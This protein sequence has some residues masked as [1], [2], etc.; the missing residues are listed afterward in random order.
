MIKVLQKKK[1][2][3]ATDNVMKKAQT[4]KQKREKVVNNKKKGISLFGFV[5]IIGLIPLLISLLI[6]SIVAITVI[7]NNLESSEENTLRVAAQNLRSYCEDNGVTAMNASDYYN[8]IDG[9]KD[10]GIELAIIAPGIP[11]TTSIKNENDFRIREI[12]LGIDLTADHALYANGYYDKHVEANEQSY[13]AYYMPVVQNGEE[14][15]VA[16]AGQLKSSVVGTMNQLV[17]LFVCITIVLFA[18][19]V[20]LV[21]LCS[22]RLSA[23]IKKVC[24]RIKALSKGDLSKHSSFRCNV[25]EVSEIVDAYDLTQE[26]LADIIG[27]VKNGA[28]E[29]VGSVQD[30]TGSSHTGAEQAELINESVEQLSASSTAIEEN[31][32]KIYRQMQEIGSSVNEINGSAEELYHSAERMM[33]TNDEANAYLGII[34]ENSENSVGAVATIAEQI[35]STNDSIAQI[36]Q[37][38]ELILSIS[39]QTNLLSLN[40]SIEAARAG[41]QGRG[42]AVV[43]QEIRTLAEQSANGAEMIRTLS[44]TINEQSE[45]SVEMMEQVQKFI[46]EEKDSIEKTRAKYEE[47]SKDISRSVTQIQAISDKAEALSDYKEKVVENVREL[48]HITEENAKNHS[49]MMENVGQI[50]DSVKQV[51]EYCIAMEKQAGE[52]DRSVDYF[53]MGS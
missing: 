40:A 34:R 12:S 32:V 47:H 53:T 38:V 44:Q 48:K 18:V 42:F 24:E 49:Q 13:Y 19:S 11:C 4:K 15:A 35:H 22:T 16:F 7:R 3:K 50:L 20:L 27:G 31:V 46:L 23:V 9:L 21:L 45:K 41:E 43:A 25:R 2:D 17:T 36:D 39:E 10:S 6:F 30:V 52:L 37:A 1:T 26:R 14:V 29:L 5:V 33:R 51:D 28:E 8:Y